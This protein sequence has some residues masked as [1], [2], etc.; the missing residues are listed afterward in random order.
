MGNLFAFRALEPTDM[1]AASDP[2]GSANDE[3]LARQVIIVI[4]LPRV[5]E[6]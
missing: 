6:L 1:F 3:W 2:I 4:D 5:L